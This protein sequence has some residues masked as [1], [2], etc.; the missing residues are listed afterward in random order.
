VTLVAYWALTPRNAAV[1]SRLR[2]CT[3][4]YDPVNDPGL[5]GTFTERALVPMLHWILALFSR[6]TPGSV[7]DE[8]RQR[9]AMAGRPMS[10]TTFMA[11][12][13]G[14]LVTLP[15]LFALWLLSQRQAPGLLQWL[16]L[17]LLVLVSYRL[18]EFWLDSRIASRKGEIGR[19][20]PD[21]LDLITVSIEAGLAMDMAMAR[22]AEKTRG[23]LAEEFRQVITEMS[24]GRMRREALRDMARRTGVDDLAS[25]IA[26]I[27]QADQTGVSVGHVLRVQS[28]Q[29]RVK[30]RQRAEEKAQ[31]LPVK[32]LF[33]LMFCILPAT[34][35][36]IL[37]PAAISIYE[38]M[39]SR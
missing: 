18:P 11:L 8:V 15:T 26:A 2:A 4:T 32:M 37:G 22:V 1:Q 21:A 13:V 38:N 14:L 10:P 31:Q 35:A 28:E 12:K 7:A 25:F 19:T 9:L 20:L 24:L 34:F 23:P 36:V 3:D 27:V 17:V 30:R 29:I 33:P 5:Q 16:L 39:I 6:A